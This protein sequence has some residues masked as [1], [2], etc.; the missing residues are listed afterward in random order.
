MNTSK[1]LFQSICNHSTM[2][3]TP[4]ILPCVKKESSLN[5]VQAGFRMP[6]MSLTL[7]SVLFLLA[8]SCNTPAEKVENAQEEVDLAT[9]DLDEA[10]KMYQVE[11]DSFKAEVNREIAINELE[12]RR[13]K[14]AQQQQNSTQSKTYESDLSDLQLKLE[15]LKIKLNNYEANQRDGWESFKTEF[16]R[17]MNHLGTALKDFTKK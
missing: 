13:L 16:K 2:M 9:S 12:I 3:Q 8:V 7:F 5:P 11:V 6:F 14:A 1:T 10:N 15:K 4:L 17:D